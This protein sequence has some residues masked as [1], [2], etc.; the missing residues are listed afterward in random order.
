MDWRD[1]NRVDGKPDVSRVDDR[2]DDNGIADGG[3]RG[4]I[5]QA[6]VGTALFANW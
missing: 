5:A 3:Q 1:G 6:R 2:P 4:E